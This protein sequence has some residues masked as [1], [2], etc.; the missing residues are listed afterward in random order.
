MVTYD[1]HLIN[2]LIVNIWK[3]NSEATYPIKQDKYI[4]IIRLESEKFVDL[5]NKQKT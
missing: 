4:A 5:S 2:D 3:K 1:S